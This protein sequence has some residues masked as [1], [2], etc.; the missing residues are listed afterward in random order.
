M[1]HLVRVQP[2]FTHK[3]NCLPGAEDPNPT[4]IEGGKNPAGW[5]PKGLNHTSFHQPGGFGHS[6]LFLDLSFLI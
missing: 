4:G 6:L 2:T 1:Q 5:E 3:G